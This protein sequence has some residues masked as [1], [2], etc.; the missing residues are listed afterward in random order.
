MKEKIRNLLIWIYSI[1]INYKI[2]PREVAKKLP[3]RVNYNVRCIGLRKG[4]IEIHS[5]SVYKGMIQIGLPQ[6]VSSHDDKSPSCLYFETENGRMIFNGRADF[7]ESIA[8][9]IYE[10]GI[11]EI[12]DGFMSN[13][14]ASINVSKGVTI[15]K[16]AQWGWNVEIIDTDGHD[17]LDSDMKKCNPDNKIVIGDDVWLGA[18]SSL[19]KGAVIPNNSVVGYGSIISKQFDEP[20]VIIVGSPGKIVKHNISWSRDKTKS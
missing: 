4:C 3:L 6:E 13:T 9:R 17:I 1:P 2:F 5:D 15:G 16:N 19:L 18:K 11:L 12:G 7:Y 8:I 10:D 14:N 20:N